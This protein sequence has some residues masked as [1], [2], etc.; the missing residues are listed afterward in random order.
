[1][2]AESEEDLWESSRIMKQDN[3]RDHGTN[4]GFAGKFVSTTTL[5]RGYVG[6]MRN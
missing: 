5:Q 3:T 4:D 2:H 6:C 1:M